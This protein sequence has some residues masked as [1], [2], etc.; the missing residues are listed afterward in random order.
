MG[1][2]LILG[3]DAFQAIVYY[4]FQEKLQKS[5]LNTWEN[6][7]DMAGYTTKKNL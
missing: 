3:G 2:T 6:S 1:L 7:A 5:S 4:S